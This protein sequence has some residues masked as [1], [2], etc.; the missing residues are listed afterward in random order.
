M[1]PDKSAEIL[2]RL[3]EFAA[4]HPEQQAPEAL[5]QLIRNEISGVVSDAEVLEILRQFKQESLGFGQL[6]ELFKIPGVTDILVNGTQGVFYDCGSGLEKARVQLSDPA[7][8]RRLATRLIVAAGRRLDDAQCFADGTLYRPD[9][10]VV[11]VHAILAPPAAQTCISLRILGTA[12]AQLDDLVASNTMSAVTAHSL[13]KLVRQAAPMLIIGGTGS[14]KTTLLGALLAEV[15]A[16]QRIIGIEDTAELAPQHH[17]FLS[18][19]ARSANVEGQGKISLS[20]LL[21]QALRMRPDRIVVGE[22]RGKEIVDLLSAMNTGHQGCAGT[23]HANTL[24]DTLARIEALAAL[25]GLTVSA[26]HAQVAA[27]A[28]YVLVMQRLLNSQTSAAGSPRR[29]LQQIGRIQTSPLRVAELW[30][31]A[32]GDFRA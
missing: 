3:E 27:A 8:V 32:Q 26:V 5:A 14:G 25:G 21:Q 1:N 10:T 9:G 18:L 12:H 6:E 17:H 13:K 29:R 19:L 22:I 11:R 24:E 4:T 23:L 2:Q 30:N 7:Q 31:A 28:P 20:H 15:P 16:N